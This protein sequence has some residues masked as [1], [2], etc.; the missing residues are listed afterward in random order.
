MIGKTISH[1]RILEKLGGGGMGVVY[2]AEDTRLGRFVALKFLPPELAKDRQAVERFQREARAASALD[3]PNICALY[4]IGEEDGQPYIVMQCLEGRTLKHRIAAQTFKVD[5]ILEMGYQLADALEAAHSKGIVHRDIKP[6]NI[7]VTER[8]EA[9]I[10]DFGLAKLANY[11]LSPSSEKRGINADSSPGSGGGQGVVDDTPTATI[12]AEHLTSPGTAMGTVAYMSPEQARG[13]ELDARTDLFSFGAVLYEMATGR[14]AFAGNT[15]AVIFNSILERAPT[16]SVR[17]NPDLPT[18]LDRIICKALEKDR[19]TRYQS[20]AEMRADLKRLKRETDSGR[21]TSVAAAEIYPAGRGD[22]RSGVGSRPGDPLKEGKSREWRGRAIVLGLL[23]FATLAVAATWWAMRRTALPPATR[24]G[25]TSVAVLPFQNMGGDQTN[26]YLRMALPDE[27]TTTLT[28]VPSLAIRPFA[29]MAKYAN[30]NFDPQT[31]GHDL[32]VADVITGHFAREGD[33]LRVTLEAVDVESNRLLWR[34]EVSVPAKDM[35]GL[36]KQLTTRV[37]QGLVPVIGGAA[38]NASNATAPRNPEAYDLFLRSLAVGHDP[39]PNKD[40][41]KMLEQAVSLDPTYAPAWVNLGQRFYYDAQYSDGGA[42]AYQRSEDATERAAALDPNMVEAVQGRIINGVE[43]GHLNDA[44]DEAQ[45]LLKRRPDSGI[46]H[47]TLAYVY[48]YGGL[49]EDAARECDA[50]L[51]ID[52]SNYGFRACSLDFLELGKYDRALDYLRLDA[53]S[54]WSTGN[55]A[56]VLLH[57]G[58]RDEALKLLESRQATG[59]RRV[60][61]LEAYLEHRPASEIADLAKQTEADLM[62]D[63]DPENKYLAAATAAL[64]GQHDQAMRLLRRAVE[65]NYCGYPAMDNDPF[66]DNIRNTPEF[67]AIHSSGIECQRKF[68]EHIAGRDSK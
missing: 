20:A 41:I 42:A 39:T 5:Q 47:F 22:R 7:F 40:A 53:G 46:A 30:G 11:P 67:A 19:E 48:T 43:S 59:N 3:H 26:D 62:A 8:G 63:R 65:D 31:A 54:V 24:N 55:V 32:K 60:S 57:Q 68:K 14:Q 66:F 44:Y 15:S 34:D 6:A 23:A 12:D 56:R 13:E 4:D 16:S 64:A 49:L 27:I 36:R 21:S 2:K 35:I 17:L 28:Y 51:A 61:L 10:L 37:Q 58:K 52:P 45:E 50:A 9:K 1:Y 18:D 25:Q 29:T 38:G 33:E